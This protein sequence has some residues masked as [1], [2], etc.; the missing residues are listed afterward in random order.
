MG[1]QRRSLTLLTIQHV[2][3]RLYS[4]TSLYELLNS[5]RLRDLREMKY[6]FP[7]I[8]LCNLKYIRTEYLQ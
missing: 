4:N 1:A 3:D 2:K 7:R 6:Y 5:A 8:T